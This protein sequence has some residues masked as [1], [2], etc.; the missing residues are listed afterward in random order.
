M[1]KTARDFHAR[2]AIDRLPQRGG[3][4]VVSSY[5]AELVLLVQMVGQR[6]RPAFCSV[7]LNRLSLLGIVYQRFIALVSPAK[8]G[9]LWSPSGHQPE[10]VPTSSGLSLHFPA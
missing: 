8:K 3:Q 6:M 5:G 1:R 2:L 10:A 7:L 4:Y 9:R